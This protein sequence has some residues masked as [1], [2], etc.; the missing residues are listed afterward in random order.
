MYNTGL[1]SVAFYHTISKWPQRYRTPSNREYNTFPRRLRVVCLCM[2]SL[3]LQILRLPDIHDYSTAVQATQ[4]GSCEE[5]ES[6]PKKSWISP[7]GLLRRYCCSCVRN[8]GPTAARVH[9]YGGMLGEVWVTR[10]VPCPC[11]QPG[12]RSEP[13]WSGG[14][15][16]QVGSGS[17]LFSSLEFNPLKLKRVSADISFHGWIP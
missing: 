14:E 4:W 10:R 2:L 3:Q 16:K 17:A 5:I 7:D 15:G 12:S 8:D 6:A 13:G 11:S 1:C 9:G